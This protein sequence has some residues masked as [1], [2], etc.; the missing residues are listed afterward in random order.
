MC[1]KF[2]KIEEDEKTTLDQILMIS[3]PSKVEFELIK[4]SSRKRYLT[5]YKKKYIN[6]S[7]DE[8]YS[9]YEIGKNIGI[10]AAAVRNILK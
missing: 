1:A 10:S 6:L 3:C 5:K 8:G 9:Y 2:N 4:A 7:K